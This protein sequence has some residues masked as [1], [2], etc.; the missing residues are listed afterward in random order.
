MKSQ[1]YNISVLVNL[2]Q[3]FKMVKKVLLEQL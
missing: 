1:R 3:D 2:H